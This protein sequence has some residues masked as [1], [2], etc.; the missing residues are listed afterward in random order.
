MK[1]TQ[2]S[3]VYRW[4][5]KLFSHHG[6]TK[7]VKEN[8]DMSLTQCNAYAS[9]VWRKFRNKFY[10]NFD[11]NRITCRRVICSNHAN[12]TKGLAYS[13]FYYVNRKK[14]YKKGKPNMY[15]KMQLPK[16]ARSKHIIIHEVSHFLAPETSMHDKKFVGVYVY[17]LHKFL[18]FDLQHMIDSLN[19]AKIEFSFNTSP[20]L[21]RKFNSAR[22]K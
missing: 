5:E 13:G 14:N 11:K 15:K 7:G 4:E 2:R 20:Y 17:L 22:K 21:N 3:K 9:M 12:G 6:L 16:W 1:D 10:Y 19:E 18:N 8:D